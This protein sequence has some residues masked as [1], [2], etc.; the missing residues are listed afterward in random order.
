MSKSNIRREVPILL[1]LY[2][3]NIVIHQGWIQAM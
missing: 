2:H 3:T 1:A